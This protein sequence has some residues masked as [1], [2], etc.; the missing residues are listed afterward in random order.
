MSTFLKGIGLEI[1]S[2]IVA[3]RKFTHYFEL[4]RRSLT[5]QNPFAIKTPSRPA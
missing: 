4:I 3:E 1:F 5:L 2:Q